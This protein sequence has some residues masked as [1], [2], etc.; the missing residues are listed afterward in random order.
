MCAPAT[1][2][3]QHL[4]DALTEIV[5]GGLASLEAAGLVRRRTD[6][7]CRAYAILFIVL[8]PVVLNRQIEARL[9]TD[10]FHPD[11]VRARSASNIDLLRHGL[12]TAEAPRCRARQARVPGAAEMQPWRQT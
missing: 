3:G 7:T 10:A 9:G 11:V 4:F 5:V 6:P 2:S 12:F 8:G 1:P